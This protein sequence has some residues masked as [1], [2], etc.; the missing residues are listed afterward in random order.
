MDNYRLGYITKLE[1]E[2]LA[3]GFSILRIVEVE[4]N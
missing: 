1:K 4:N 2:T 3:R